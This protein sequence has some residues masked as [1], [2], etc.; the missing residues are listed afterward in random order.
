[1][2]YNKRRRERN[3]KPPW[4]RKTF[5]KS[6]YNKQHYQANKEKIK[7]RS[8]EYYYNHLEK[9]KRYIKEYRKK[10]KEKISLYRREYQF[11]KKMERNQH[12]ERSVEES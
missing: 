4:E 9:I 7:K 12:G 8:R 1:M 6:E 11:R 5:N 10:N 3:R 2:A